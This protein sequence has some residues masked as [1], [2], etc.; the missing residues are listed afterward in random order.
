MP[1][2]WNKPIAAADAGRVAGWARTMIGRSINVPALELR[3]AVI[4]AVMIDLEGVQYSIAYFHNGER[5]TA[6]VFRD[7]FEMNDRR[8][9]HNNGKQDRERNPQ[10]RTRVPRTRCPDVAVFSPSQGRLGRLL[11]AK[12]DEKVSRGSDVH[13]WR[14]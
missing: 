2:D 1:T 14:G 6:W 3:R 8:I 7:E 5:K 9:R 10:I 13:R 11:E 4:R 12:T